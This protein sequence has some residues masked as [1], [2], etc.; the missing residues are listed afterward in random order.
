MNPARHRLVERPWLTRLAFALIAFAFVATVLWPISMHL[1]ADRHAGA[2][3]ADALREREDARLRWLLSASAA[4]WWAHCETAWHKRFELPEQPQAIAWRR[5]QGVHGYYFEGADRRSLRQ[6][7]CTPYG[8][9][10]GPRAHHPLR[11]A[12]PA[13]RA[14]EAPPVDYH[15][16]MSALDALPDVSGSEGVTEVAIE[17]LRHPID[18]RA[19]RRSWSIGGVERGPT[20]GPRVH[21][22]D[23]VF[24]LLLDELPLPVAA[25]LRPPPL[26]YLQARRWTEVPLEAIEVVAAAAPPGSKIVELK[27]EPDRI[28]AQIGG[29]IPAFDGDP[30][31]PFGALDFDE[32][33]IATRDW[34]YPYRES[35]FG[36]DDG[37][38][39]EELRR[40]LIES[41]GTAGAHMLWYSCSPA[42]SD[43][44]TGQ[45]HAARH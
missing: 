26:E 2:R 22:E 40:S 4:T 34:W 1:L 24:A 41:G 23:E 14:E 28:H 25:E 27:I 44:V 33:G 31:A 13:E 29:Q 18:G 20:A 17:L 30:P 36:C 11:Q 10:K 38:A 16:W 3:I 21:S 45:W 35:G 12:L 32:Y 39:P 42:Y 6:Y 15:G 8:V 37:L 5:G 7:R 19:L 9:A 43:T